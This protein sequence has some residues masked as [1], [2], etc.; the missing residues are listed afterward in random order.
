MEHENLSTLLKQPDTKPG[1]EA[2]A[3]SPHAHILLL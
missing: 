1:P 3:S 2:A